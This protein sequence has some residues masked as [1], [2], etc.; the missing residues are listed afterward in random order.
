[1]NYLLIKISSVDEFNGILEVLT[2]FMSNDLY[3][4]QNNANDYFNTDKNCYFTLC[5]KKHNNIV[6]LKDGTGFDLNDRFG[7][8]YMCYEQH[9]VEE[10]D[11]IIDLKDFSESL[12]K[13]YIESSKFNLL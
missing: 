13:Q 3:S 8:Y 4:P 11:I 6:K 7:E 12:V 9:I 1:M 5:I 2:K 10:T